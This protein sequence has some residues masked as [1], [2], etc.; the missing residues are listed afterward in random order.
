[1]HRIVIPLLAPVPVHEQNGNRCYETRARGLAIL[2]SPL[3]EQRD[4]LQ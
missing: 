1:M 4:S 3:L 2:N